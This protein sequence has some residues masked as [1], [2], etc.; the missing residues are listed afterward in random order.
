ME[1]IKMLGISMVI[2]WTVIAVL[3]TIVESMTLGLTTIWFAIGALVAIIAAA[4]N[5][6]IT[7]QITI[8]LIVSIVLLVY[9]RPIAIKV[10]KVGS[11]K[12]NV[13]S[14]IGKEGLVVKTMEHFEKGHVKVKGQIWSAKSVDGS[15]ILEGERIVVEAI[16]GV[17]LI[18][19]KF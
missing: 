13:D 9:T 17:K 19:R 5:L 10:L 8:F 16:E 3:L 6:H 2:V 7:V 14:L 4:L 1:V 15:E 11:T 12:T 18:V